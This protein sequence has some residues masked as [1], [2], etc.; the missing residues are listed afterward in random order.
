MVDEELA[1]AGLVRPELAIGAW[2]VPTIVDHG[3]AEQAQKFVEPTLL[4]DL[5]WCQL[6][7]E[8]GAGSDLAA[9]S[10]RAVKT[11]GGWQLT[12]QKVWTS[13]ARE[14]DWAICLERTDRDARH[15]GIT[16]F[17]VDMAS[18][19]IDIR[20]LREL[21]GRDSFRLYGV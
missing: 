12:G 17:V 20:P 10:T 21:T 1:R 3:T 14:A 11:E 5:I 4:G 9:L 16:Y 15:K 13:R 2:A 7:S 18:A 8:P 19:G 6:F